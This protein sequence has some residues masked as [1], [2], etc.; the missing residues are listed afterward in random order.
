[1][2]YGNICDH[3]SPVRL[4]TKMRFNL[5]INQQLL[6]CDLDRRAQRSAAGWSSFRSSGRLSP[7]LL[8]HVIAGCTLWLTALL[9]D[10]LVEL[11]P[12]HTCT[13]CRTS[14]KH[15]DCSKPHT[16]SLFQ[17]ERVISNIHSKQ[18]IVLIYVDTGDWQEPE[19]TKL[20]V[21]QA[22][23]LTAVAEAQIN[24]HARRG[25]TDW[26]QVWVYSGLHKSGVNNNKKTTCSLLLFVIFRQQINNYVLISDDLQ[27][28]SSTLWWLKSQINSLRNSNYYFF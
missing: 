9:L 28:L 21:L 24:I 26:L 1:M 10:M 16:T 12:S 14:F 19:A 22:N 5:S 15:P 11:C 7:A 2:Q 13:H 20:K 23:K 17:K 27:R 6:T 25:C 18:S 4:M 8:P 3:H